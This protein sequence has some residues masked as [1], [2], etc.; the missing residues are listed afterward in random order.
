MG[1]G[2]LIIKDAAL[3]VRKVKLSPSVLLGHIKA[4][5][6]G[7]AKFPVK[8]EKIKTFSVAAS[9]LIVN[10]ENLFLGQLLNRLMFG[11]VE[12]QSFV[13]QSSKNPYNFTHFDTDYVALF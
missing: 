4:F 11:L 7:M 6:R 8:R 12:N 13:G 5:G 1:D 9:N 2:K 3:Y 10:H